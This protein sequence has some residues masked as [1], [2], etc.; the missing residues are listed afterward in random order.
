MSFRTTEDA[1]EKYIN[2]EKSSFVND[3]DKYVNDKDSI[4]NTRVTN[5]YSRST[6]SNKHFNKCNDN[7]ILDYRTCLLHNNPIIV[8]VSDS[9]NKQ[10]KD[11]SGSHEINDNIEGIDK[12][13][14]NTHIKGIDT[15]MLNNTAPVINN[16]LFDNR[17][18]I[19][20][21]IDYGFNTYNNKYNNQETHNNN[22]NTDEHSNNFNT[23]EHNNNE[24]ITS[25]KH[26]NNNK[27]ITLDEFVNI[28]C[29]NKNTGNCNNKNTD[30][31]NN[32][33]TKDFITY[34]KYKITKNHDYE[35]LTKSSES[36][37]KYNNLNINNKSLYNNKSSDISIINSNTNTSDISTINSNT[38][39]INTIT[40]DI[41]SN[42]SIPRKIDCTYKSLKYQIRIVLYII[43]ILLLLILLLFLINRL[44]DSAEE[45]LIE[46]NIQL[47]SMNKEV[48]MHIK[49][50]SFKEFHDKGYKD[51][52]I[53]HNTSANASN[54]NSTNNTN[55]TGNTNNTIEDTLDA[56]NIKDTTNLY[57]NNTES[58]IFHNTE[59]H[60]MEVDNK[61]VNINN[62]H[63]KDSSINTHMPYR[64]ANLEVLG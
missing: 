46:E 4:T 11:Y 25:G 64:I 47:Q 58:H 9:L 61:A 34:D 3:N 21:Y 41:N 43:L 59:L 1:N 42:T 26:N 44:M 27:Y 13:I 20:V 2:S 63:I 33:N 52:S 60:N 22:F 45:K 62:S 54:A 53:K 24:Y 15:S 49:E 17:V 16:I 28:N 57:I 14:K 6:D 32:K 30:N 55:N 40:S 12:Y 29:D 48:D 39:D 50:E 23:D 19:N 37:T 31:C 38:S 8:N 36:S 51:I 10:L 18:N 35:K 7:C 56:C 5:D